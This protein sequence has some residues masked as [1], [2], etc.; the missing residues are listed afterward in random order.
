MLFALQI[1]LSFV[2]SGFLGVDDSKGYGNRPK[3]I[4]ISKSA[5]SSTIVFFDK[6]HA[7]I[8][9][10]NSWEDY[11]LPVVDSTSL[12]EDNA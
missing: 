8:L 9:G 6:H 3:D 1:T 12:K 11:S 10:G 7:S 5:A 2:R 4:S